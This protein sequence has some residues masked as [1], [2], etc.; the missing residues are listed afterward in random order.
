MEISYINGGTDTTIAKYG[1]I[2]LE[3]HES[4]YGWKSSQIDNTIKTNHDY[5]DQLSLEQKEQVL[6][7]NSKLI[8]IIKDFLTGKQTR[9]DGTRLATYIRNN[10]LDNGETEEDNGKPL[11]IKELNKKRI[12]LISQIIGDNNTEL[13]PYAIYNNKILYAEGQLGIDA[14]HLQT[15]KMSEETR[16][17]F[18]LNNSFDPNIIGLNKDIVNYVEYAQYYNTETM[19]TITEI[20]R[21]D[22]NGSFNWARSILPINLPELGEVITDLTTGSQEISDSG[23]YYEYLQKLGGNNLKENQK[24]LEQA[25]NLLQLYIQQYNNYNEKYNEYNKE[26]EEYNSIFNSFIG[27]EEMKYYLNDNNMTLEDYRKKVKQAWWAF[28]R[29]LDYKYTKEREKGM[30]AQ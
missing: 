24:L 28:L 15:L 13:S 9:D 1:D 23:F 4:V 29:I 21:D 20:I 12:A 5:Y 7:I 25:N 16:P 22:T 17:F 3:N 2:E 10:Y 11:S 6:L 19:E 27:T 30:Y 26:F 18:L 8:Q 14:E